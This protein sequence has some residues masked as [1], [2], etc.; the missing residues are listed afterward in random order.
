LRLFSLWQGLIF[1]YKNRSNFIHIY[2]PLTL[3]LRRSSRDISDS[4]PSHPRFTKMTA[5]RNTVDVTGVKSYAFWSH[6]ISGVNPLVA[7]YDI[8]RRKRE[9]LFFCSVSVCLSHTTRDI[10]QLHTIFKHK[11]FRR[12]NVWIPVTLPLILSKRFIW[13]SAP[14]LHKHFYSTITVPNW[15]IL[16]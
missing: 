1:W 13:D 12:Y 10:M 15:I 8:H 6:S 16:T 4:P 7:F 9:V 5:M 2:M 14:Q 3:Y 11:I